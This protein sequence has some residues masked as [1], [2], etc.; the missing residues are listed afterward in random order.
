MVRLPTATYWRLRYLAVDVELAEARAALAVAQ[1]RARLTAA[2]PA[3]A[4]VTTTPYAWD[5]DACALVPVPGPPT[6][7]PTP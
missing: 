4:N 3:E 7:E 2:W 1:A 5:D 6:T